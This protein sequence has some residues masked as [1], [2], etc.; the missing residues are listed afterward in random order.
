MGVT[1]KVS[2]DEVKARRA[3]VSLMPREYQEAS[4]QADLLTFRNSCDCAL[5][6]PWP[7]LSVGAGTPPQC[8]S[9]PQSSGSASQYCRRCFRPS[10]ANEVDGPAKPLRRL[11]QCSQDAPRQQGT[12]ARSPNHSTAAVRAA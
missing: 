6:V 2:L 8:C 9:Y 7:R 10:A 3:A 11:K 12:G 5:V 1:A 4:D